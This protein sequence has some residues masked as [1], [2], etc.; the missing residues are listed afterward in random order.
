MSYH[1][2]PWLPLRQ[3][4]RPTKGSRDHVPHFSEAPHRAPT[5][6]SVSRPGR[7]RDRFDSTTQRQP[8][9]TRL[10]RLRITDN[11]DAYLRRFFQ[12][13]EDL[14]WKGVFVPSPGQAGPSK[15]FIDDPPRSRI[16][17]RDKRIR[18]LLIRLHENGW[19]TGMFFSKL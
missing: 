6:V 5:I 17:N 7:R 11:Q 9:T 10:D 12:R 16:S 3:T 1:L 14:P 13:S 4:I 2:I 18:G 19:L 8:T 15:S